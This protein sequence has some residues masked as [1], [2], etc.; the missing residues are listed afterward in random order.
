[1]KKLLFI[2]TSLL[3]SFYASAAHKAEFSALSEYRGIIQCEYCTNSFQFED[4]A[5]SISNKQ[6]GKYL[7]INNA[8]Q[9]A[10]EVSLF[11]EFEI[12]SWLPTTSFTNSD[13]LYLEKTRPARNVVVGIPFHYFSDQP[14]LANMNKDILTRNMRNAGLFN[15]LTIFGPI[16][17][18]VGTL[19]TVHFANG[20]QVQMILTHGSGIIQWTVLWETAIDKDGNPIGGSGGNSGGG[21]DSGNGSGSGVGSGGGAVYVFTYGGTPA[22]GYT[23]IFHCDDNGHCEKIN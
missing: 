7:V 18:L 12:R 3:F 19:V 20:D 8:A 14:N 22:G 21:N 17:M 9:L 6:N 2:T 5:L 13:Q 16:N 10:A 11:Y 4:S 23:E 1:M 15:R